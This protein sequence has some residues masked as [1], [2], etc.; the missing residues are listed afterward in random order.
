MEE[1]EEESG[2]TA[3]SGF[4]VE[5]LKSYAS[6][7][8]RAIRSRWLLSST[9]LV[10]GLVLTLATFELYPRTYR[11]KTVMLAIG[12]SVLD[13]YDAPNP[14]A[15]ASGLIM[16]HDNLEAIIREIGL[17]RTYGVRRPPL[18]RLKD[19]IVGALMG[20]PSDK[21]LVAILVATIE[22]KLDVSVDKGEL[23]VAVDWSD[24]K[25]AAELVEA[26]RRSFLNA[27]HAAEVSA[28]E[29]KMTI[30]DGHATKLR[31][32]ISLL[33]DQ[34]NASRHN[35]AAPVAPGAA[36]APS[37]RPAV[38]RTVV[39]AA[40][41]ALSL[42]E[43]A[44]LKQKL[45]VDKPKLAALE[46]EHRRQVRDEENKLADLKLRLT[47]SHPQVVTEQQRLALV[48]QLPAELV[49]LRAEVATLET[50]IKAH[51][52]TVGRT[53]SVTIS[54]GAAAGAATTAEPLP[55]EIM[56]ALQKDD[57]DPALREQLSGAVV[58]YGDLRGGLRTARIDLDTAQA[59]FNR[60]YQVVVPAEAPSKAEKPKPGL[61][62]GGGLVA[63]L[64]LALLLP[65]LG[66]L[67]KGVIIERWQV[68]QLQLPV[69]G[70]LQ[71][72]PHNE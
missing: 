15:D 33:A 39:P 24:G 3:A 59:A 68:H 67:R 72:P 61:I 21:D 19:R 4:Q 44:G 29:D 28:F 37:P 13:R 22:T 69:L 56:Q 7:A 35:T 58:K 42:Q 18:L 62:L 47:P 2:E 63:T 53:T 6:F 27:R 5:Q 46:D 48:S 32:E 26:A 65:I 41:D 23:T 43:L 51:E 60:R 66:E 14:L 49:Q 50:D 9:L 38:V 17:Q 54:G 31:D 1:P 20:R 34:V 25:T 30:L 12:G 57:G 36:P 71:L 52:L 40:P 45:A 55:A 10:V 11:C 64:A 8:R 70:E 16:R